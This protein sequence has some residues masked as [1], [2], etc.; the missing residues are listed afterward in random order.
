MHGAM[1]TL[2]TLALSTLL[3]LGA[4]S[5]A[6]E[7]PK[8]PLAG[9]W[10]EVLPEDQKGMTLTFSHDGKQLSVHGRPREDESHSHPSA[11]V[12]F[13]E[14]TM[15]LT[16]RGKILDGNAAESWTGKL[17]GEAF[18]LTGGETKLK[19]KKGGKPHGH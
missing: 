1:K 5:A 18:V 8:S 7:G 10:S 12:E 9:N 3:A 16:I 15:A 19:F 6:D 13:D 2:H 11:T 4:C 14:K 17:A